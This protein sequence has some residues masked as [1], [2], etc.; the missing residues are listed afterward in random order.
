[1]WVGL[2]VGLDEGF[3]LLSNMWSKRNFGSLNTR[4]TGHI[5]INL[6]F[7][8]EKSLNGVKEKHGKRTLRMD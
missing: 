6:K 1:M 3:S 7:L 5:I 2:F 4:G 8:I